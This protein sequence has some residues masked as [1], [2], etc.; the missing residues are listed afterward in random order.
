MRF[1]IDQGGGYAIVRLY[2]MV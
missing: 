2:Q 1:S